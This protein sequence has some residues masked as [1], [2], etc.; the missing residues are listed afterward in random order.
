MVS[1]AG[2]HDEASRKHFLSFS[3]INV[4]ASHNHREWHHNSRAME[5]KK[6]T[7]KHWYRKSGV[8]PK[9]PVLHLD[10]VQLN[11][12]SGEESQIFVGRCTIKT[13][14]QG[15]SP[16]WARPW[17]SI[18]RRTH[19]YWWVLK[20]QCVQGQ[21]IIFINCFLFVSNHLKLRIKIL[22]LAQNEYFISTEAAGPLHSTMLHRRVTTV[23]ASSPLDATEC[24]T[25]AL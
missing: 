4:T 8:K 13:K 6:H 11:D 1:D 15:E 21:N 14:R 17:L 22:S 25:L 7:E 18:H 16:E 19:D 10:R 12:R 9:T 5:E 23:S 3:M 24:Y 2:C 20:D